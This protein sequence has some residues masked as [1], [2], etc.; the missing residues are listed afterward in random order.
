MKKTLILSSIVAIALTIFCFAVATFL[1]H[2]VI[3]Q[4]NARKKELKTAYDSGFNK[5]YRQAI[6]ALKCMDNKN[7]RDSALFSAYFW[8]QS[9]KENIDLAEIK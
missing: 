2:V 9:E 5:A 8:I 6:D 3:N 4:E 1:E 7:I